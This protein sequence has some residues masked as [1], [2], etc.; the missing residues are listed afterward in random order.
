[1]K[2]YCNP[3]NLEYK[4]QYTFPAEGDLCTVYREAADP[5]LIMFKGKYYLFV[6]M[7]LGF[8]T[9]DDLLNWEYHA[10]KQEMPVYDYA[11]DVRVMGDYM[12]FSA[13]RRSVNCSFYRTKDPL[14]EPFEEIPGTFP[15]WDPNL[16]IDDDGKVYFYWGCSNVTPIYGV[17]MD[18]ATMIP[19]TDP[20]VMFDSDIANLG[21]ERVGDD[22]VP[23]RSEEE[24]KAQIDAAMENKAALAARLGIPEENVRAALEKMISNRPY[25]EGA[26]M[27]KH[28][29]RYYL[30]YAIPGTEFNVYSDCV[31]VG[32]N[33]LGPFVPARSNPFS[34]KP[35]GFINGAGHGSTL[36]AADGRY[37]HI[38]SMRISHNHMFERRLGIWK[39]GFDK[40]GD[41]FCDQRYGDWPIDI[42]APAFAK[43]EWMLLSYKKAV[44][45]SSGSGMENITDE[46]VRTWWR[47]STNNP[48]EWVQVDLGREYD[49]R[50]IQINF[51]DDMIK[52]HL[53]LGTRESTVVG[54]DRYIDPIKHPTRW[55]LEGSVDGNE[56][57]VIEDKR[58]AQ[59]DLAHD[60]ILREEG[61]MVRYIR[62]TVS[63]L[64]YGAVP[65]VSGIRV[66]GNCPGEAPAKAHFTTEE[67]GDL[68]VNVIWDEIPGAHAN[69][70]W[71]CAPDKLYHSYMVFGKN[72]QH[73][74]ALAKGAEVYMRVDTFN[75]SGITEG[76]VKKVR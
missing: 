8:W 4:Y 32:E 39:T 66:F 38:G 75:E 18:P 40:D 20:L 46:D 56:Y 22:H 10:F 7:S 64:P 57:F 1:M 70:L 6:S 55:I 25:I 60:F 65:T 30:Q 26:W 33:P 41:L 29:G 43:P 35:G 34:Y 74:G 61:L 11:P 73:I 63:Q 14:N 53:P 37:W 24:I 71:G 69:I 21:Y 23:P 58:L 51:A 68:D 3:M 31:Y 13:S 76:E 9:S 44:T 72:S 42:D 27:T 16:F 12:Y 47:A 62:L 36:E 50:A 45:A 28:D 54:Q 48:G 15:F 59:T 17:E 67:M 52:E 5:S 19:K 2:F 49:V